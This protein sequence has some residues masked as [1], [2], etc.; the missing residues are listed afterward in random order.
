MPPIRETAV[1][2]LPVLETRDDGVKRKA[3]NDEVVLILCQDTIKRYLDLLPTRLIEREIAV[4][5]GIPGDDLTCQQGCSMMYAVGR[6]RCCT[7]DARES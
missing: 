6:N 2:E 3:F 4:G 1:G 7:I 5:E